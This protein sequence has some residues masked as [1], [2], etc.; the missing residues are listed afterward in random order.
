MRRFHVADMKLVS[1]GA[2]VYIQLSC[3]CG[4]WEWLALSLE[5]GTAVFKEHVND[6]HP[7]A[8]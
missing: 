2:T 1:D 3:S 5:D 7:Y 4:H 6:P 8:E